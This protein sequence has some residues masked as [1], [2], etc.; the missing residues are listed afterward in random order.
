MLI[1]CR[2]GPVW[3]ADAVQ[4]HR[5][6]RPILGPVGRTQRPEWSNPPRAPTAKRWATI[7]RHPSG[8]L[9]PLPPA[10][11]QSVRLEIRSGT[12]RTCYAPPDLPVPCTNFSAAPS[13]VSKA[14]WSS[15]D[16]TCVYPHPPLPPLRPCVLPY[17]RLSLAPHRHPQALIPRPFPTSH[18]SSSHSRGGAQP[19]RGGTEHGRGGAQ[20]GRGGI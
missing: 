2:C 19:G 11:A 10:G 20:H 5:N 9:P 8:P 7:I 14:S 3:A 16:P 13:N 6:R 18:S 4:A 12:D 15:P 17:T 1:S